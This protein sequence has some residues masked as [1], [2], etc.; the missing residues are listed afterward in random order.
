MRKEEPEKAK[1]EEERAEKPGRGI[2]R[3]DSD[4]E[5]GRGNQKE[6]VLPVR[7]NPSPCGFGTA[8]DRTLI[9]PGF[10]RVFPSL[11]LNHSERPAAK[12]GDFGEK[13]VAGP[14]TR[15]DEPGSETY[16]RANGEAGEKREAVRQGDGLPFTAERNAENQQETNGADH[17]GEG[18]KFGPAC[19]PCDDSREGESADAV[20]GLAESNQRPAET[21]DREQQ[22]APFDVRDRPYLRKHRRARTGER[23]DDRRGAILRQAKGNRPRGEDGESD[24]RGVNELGEV[25]AGPR[26]SAKVHRQE[27]V[28]LDVERK[29]GKDVV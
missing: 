28:H 8:C 5:D 21:E 12:L 2:G 4:C 9:G 25:H 14:E 23:G 13:W 16:Y 18:G 11:G 24:E 10:E 7:K 22:E 15:A 3:F 26:S 20:V 6:P 29:I 19:Q 27:V 17:F 1:E